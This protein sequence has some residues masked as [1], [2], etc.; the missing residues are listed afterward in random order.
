MREGVRFE[1]Y[2]YRKWIPRWFGLRR[3][4]CRRDLVATLRRLQ[5]DLCHFHEDGLTM[6]VAA[7][8][9]EVLPDTK[10][11]FDFHEFFLHRLRLTE[12]TQRGLQHYVATENRVL[13]GADGVITVSDFMSQYYR[14]L[15]DKPVVTVM[16]SQSARVFAAGDKPVTD[17]GTFWV[18][19]EGRMVFDRGLRLLVEAARLVQSPRVRF[20]L[21]G[22][23][24]PAERD[25]FSEQ[26]ARDG[27]AGLFQVTGM[28]PYQQVP[29]WLRR[30]HAGLCLN[31][32]PNALMGT[33]NK[34][35]NYVRFGL[36]VLTL[37]HP[38]MGP[39]VR[40]AN[41]GEVL[42]RPGVARELAGAIDRLATDPMRQAALSAAAA[43]LFSDE[44][45]WEQME[46]RL[47]ALYQE[48]LPLETD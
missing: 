22:D 39:F 36:P 46:R 32:T 31:E 7:K 21:I 48:V 5:P 43:G 2:P 25:Y 1:T 29:E 47:L 44:L 15:T 19:H 13:A 14:T 41:C 24:P 28:L 42:T 3:A 38:V 17:D 8:L 6:D 16:N 12:E 10:L 30:G 4:I 18:V 45:N 40:R 11:I 27:T 37:E 33:P 34:F 23:L 20:L 9:K 26:T 35:F